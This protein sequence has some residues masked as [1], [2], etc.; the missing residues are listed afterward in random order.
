MEVAEDVKERNTHWLIEGLSGVNILAMIGGLIAV[1]WYIFEVRAGQ[2]YMAQRLVQIEN[3]I[4]ELAERGTRIAELGWETTQLRGEYTRLGAQIE[5]LQDQ[6]RDIMSTMR[7]IERG[8]ES[9]RK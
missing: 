8:L 3:E 9:N 7:D 1:A 6:N 2:N 4:D 5:R